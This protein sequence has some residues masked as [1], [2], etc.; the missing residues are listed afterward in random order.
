[1][2]RTLVFCK[3]TMAF[4]PNNGRRLFL[5]CLGTI[6]AIAFLSYWQQYDGLLG[7]D[8]LQPVEL[9]LENTRKQLDPSSQQTPFQLW[10][11]SPMI[12][13][14]APSIGLPIDAFQDIIALC[15]VLFGAITGFAICQHGSLFFMQWLC[16]LTLYK[17]GQTFYSFQWDILL[18]EVGFASMFYAQWL[19]YHS[20]TSF[21]SSKE[22]N[23]KSKQQIESAGSC[24][25]PL[26]FIFFKLMLMSG[27]VKIQSMC[28]TWLHLTALEYHFATQCL[29]TPLAWL[30][31]QTPF[32]L[33][34]IGVAA[35][36]IIEI[37]CTFM[38]IAPNV[39][40]RVIGV[41]LQLLLQTLIILTGIIYICIYILFLS[42][43][44]PFSC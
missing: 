36:F 4:T 2:V 6:Y 10:L 38:L 1:M 20:L 33:L 11:R 3:Q 27:V 26:R 17:S 34:R 30:A 18:L 31:H 13:W 21:Y 41:C 28:P 12:S 32:P 22:L 16:Y 25:W 23:H 14:F 42:F 37:P 39:Q 44:C 9:F 43:F 24:I 8:G 19:P 40:I 35:T 5:S 7:S 29:P 15:G